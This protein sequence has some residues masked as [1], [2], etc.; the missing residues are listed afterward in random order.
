MLTDFLTYFICRRDL[1]KCRNGGFGI[2]QPG[3]S[4][5]YK[6]NSAGNTLALALLDKSTKTNDYVV[7]VTGTVSSDGISLQTTSIVE[8]VTY[9]GYLIDLF[10]WDMTNHIA[11]DGANLATNPAAH[12]VDCM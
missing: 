11:V 12:S 9:T 3:Y 4:L 6:L 5:K 10:C 2:L 1:Q 8:V 7:T